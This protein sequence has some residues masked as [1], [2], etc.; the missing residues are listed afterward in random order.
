MPK[1]HTTVPR[2]QWIVLGWHPFIGLF[3]PRF[4]WWDMPS[5]ISLCLVWGWSKHN[6]GKTNNFSSSLPSICCKLRYFGDCFLSN[7]RT[8]LSHAY[9]KLLMSIYWGHRPFLHRYTQFHIFGYSITLWI[10]YIYPHIVCF[11]KLCSIKNMLY[12]KT[13]QIHVVRLILYKLKN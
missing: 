11:V 12:T 4:Q 2:V 3:A 13:K 9:F 8:T 1:E 10:N 5:S 7:G 6:A